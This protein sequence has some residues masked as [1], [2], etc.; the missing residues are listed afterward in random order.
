MEARLASRQ[1]VSE[2]G[3]SER[4]PVVAFREVDPF[5]L[6]LWLEL[7]APLTATER[8]L[9]GSALKSWFVV[10]KLGGYNAANMQVY[11]GAAG[12]LSYLVRTATLCWWC[13]ALCSVERGRCVGCVMR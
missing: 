10:G 9:L 11:H 3:G 2:R 6:T 12:D 5:D 7:A 1:I 13:G 8:D 4:P